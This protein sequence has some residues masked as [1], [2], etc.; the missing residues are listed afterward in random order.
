MLKTSTFRTMSLQSLKKM[1]GFTLPEALL[2]RPK[3][4]NSVLGNSEILDAHEFICFWED[5]FD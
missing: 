5:T 1:G 2:V 4:V 3:R